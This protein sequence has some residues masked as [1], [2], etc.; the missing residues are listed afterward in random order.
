MSL[1][2]RAQAGVFAPQLGH[3]SGGVEFEHR[4]DVEAGAEHAGPAGQHDAPG[5]TARRRFDRLAQ[6]AAQMEVEGVD[7]RH[8]EN[9]LGDMVLD[10]GMDRHGSGPR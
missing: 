10:L 2:A 7:R 8:V 9:D 5:A 1:R 4:G 3:A 6:R